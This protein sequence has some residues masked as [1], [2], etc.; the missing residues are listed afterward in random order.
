MASAKITAL[1]IIKWKLGAITSDISFSKY[2]APMQVTLKLS[3]KASLQ[4]H[5]GCQSIS[6]SVMFKA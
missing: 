2:I 6:Q 4:L 1:A 5:I 3:D